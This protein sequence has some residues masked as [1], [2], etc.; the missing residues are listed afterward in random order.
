MAWKWTYLVGAPC[1]WHDR[2][3]EEE[4][5]PKYTLMNMAKLSQANEAGDN[6]LAILYATVGKGCVGVYENFTM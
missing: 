2:C 3:K 5:H 6:V 4:T 1:S